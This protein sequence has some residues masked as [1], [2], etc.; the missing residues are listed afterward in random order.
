VQPELQVL[1]DHRE[2]LVPPVPK[3]DKE[4]REHKDQPGFKGPQALQVRPALQGRKAHKEQLVLLVFKDQQVQL[5]QQ[6][7][8]G[9][10]D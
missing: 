7:R 5:A 3:E 6:V 2:Q 4:F 9:Q 1:L 8:Q 10:L